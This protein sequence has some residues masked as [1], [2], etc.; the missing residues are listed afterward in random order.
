M[1]V[2]KTA[3]MGV[4]SYPVYILGDAFKEMAAFAFFFYKRRIE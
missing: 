4:L 2:Q 3:D 1:N